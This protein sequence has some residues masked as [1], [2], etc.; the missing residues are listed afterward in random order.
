MMAVCLLTCGYQ[1]CESG[2]YKC[3]LQ[4]L[5]D[6]SHV[7]GIAPLNKL[8]SIMLTF[9][10]FNKLNYVRAF[11]QNISTIPGTE[12][13]NQLLMCFGILSVIC[14]PMIGF[15]DVFYDMKMHCTFTS[16]FVI[17]EVGYVCTI[18]SVLKNHR[19]YY[20][21]DKAQKQINT[22]ILMRA[23]IVI[24]GIITYGTKYYGI[25]IGAG[26][27]II[28]WAVFHETFYVFA[29]LTELMPYTL[30]VVRKDQ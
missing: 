16:L 24:E 3:N 15:F 12:Q 26:R 14:A 25:D 11:Y 27:N 29:V 20:P 22:M 21:G 4:E 7:M 19:D 1:A 28:E 8:Y 23:I 6:V 13:K 17:G 30:K 5:P 10:S 2:R 9:Y 18:T